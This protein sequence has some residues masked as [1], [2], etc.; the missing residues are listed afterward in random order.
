MKIIAVFLGMAIWTV[1][2]LI[3]E[4]KKWDKDKSGHY[5]ASEYLAFFQAHFLSMLLGALLGMVMLIEGAEAVWA[6][7]PGT[8]GVPVNNMM[9]YG[10]GVLALLVQLAVKGLQN[11]YNGSSN[12]K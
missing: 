3:I 6:A 10:S 12:G 2:M 1:V 5:N 9:Y 7:V 4:L 11:K 8:E